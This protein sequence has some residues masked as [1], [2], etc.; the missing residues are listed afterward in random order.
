[1]NIGQL[2]QLITDS[3]LPDSAEVL[4]R[5]RDA[6]ML[7]EVD[8]VGSNIIPVDYKTQREYN[9]AR[10]V[11]RDAYGV[12]VYFHEN[13]EDVYGGEHLEE[14][15]IKQAIVFCDCD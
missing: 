4:A 13:P 7:S 11:Y 3:G 12:S 15:N 10:K 14:D 1:M 6:I 8:V 9:K 5:D 2:K